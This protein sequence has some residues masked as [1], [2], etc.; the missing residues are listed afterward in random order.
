MV[1]RTLIISLLIFPLAPIAVIYFTQVMCREIWYAKYYLPGEDGGEAE[2]A[3]ALIGIP[4]ILIAVSLLLGGLTLLTRWGLARWLSAVL[5]VPL[6]GMALL[7]SLTATV[8]FMGEALAVLSH[9]EVT[10]AWMAWLASAGLFVMHQW[11]RLW[12]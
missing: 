8:F 10:I 4:L 12:R 6:A 1:P 3:M 9:W 7:L 2:P 5:R 11:D